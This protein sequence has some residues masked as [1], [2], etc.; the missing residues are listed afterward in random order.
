[1][2]H[3]KSLNRM[4]QGLHTPEL[5]S[6]RVI[7][8]AHFIVPKSRHFARNSWDIAFRALGDLP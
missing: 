8:M 3:G 6:S 7:V 2:G 5:D 4:V 1:M